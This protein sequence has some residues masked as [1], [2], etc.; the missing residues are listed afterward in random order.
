MTSRYRLFTAALGL[1]G[2]IAAAGCASGGSFGGSPEKIVTERAQ[3]RW[4]ALIDQNWA[5]AYPYMT[6]AYRAI[7]PLK[8]YG[9][10]FTGPARWEGAKVTGAKCEEKRCQVGVAVSIRL[11]MPAHSNRVDTTNIQETWV[12]ED[13]QWFKYEPM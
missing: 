12:L 10:Q 5:A 8:R 2:A 13:G 6:P 3:A 11:L 1:W 4:N 9:D 7:V